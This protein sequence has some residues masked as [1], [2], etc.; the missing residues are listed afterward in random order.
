[1]QWGLRAGAG[2]DN[3]LTYSILDGVS[4]QYEWHYTVINVVAH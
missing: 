2:R 1:M 4:R 3:E